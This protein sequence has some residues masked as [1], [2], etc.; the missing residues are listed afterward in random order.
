MSKLVSNNWGGGKG[1]GKSDLVE[2]LENDTGDEA[3]WE[4]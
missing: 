4:M 2:T 1:G 3:E